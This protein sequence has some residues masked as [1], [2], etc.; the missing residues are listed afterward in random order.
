MSMPI[1]IF[2]FV[3]LIAISFAPIRTRLLSFFAKHIIPINSCLI[4][5]EYLESKR[6]RWSEKEGKR[7]TE[8]YK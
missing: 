2:H 3:V 1:K 7:K 8:G 5:I 6:K 4:V